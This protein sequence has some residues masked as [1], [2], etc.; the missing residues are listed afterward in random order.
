MPSTSHVEW[1][2]SLMEGSGTIEST[3]GSVS[4]TY[5][6]N[7]RFG[8]GTGTNPEELLAAAHASCFSMALAL[9]LD[10]AGHETQSIETDAHVYLRKQGAGYEIHKIELETAATVPGISEEDFREHAE[11][12]KRGCPVSKALASVP[13]ITVEAKLAG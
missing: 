4:A 3:T 6:A 10:R 5:E 2:G 7:S 8:G 9:V 12:A 1:T 11:T 13:E